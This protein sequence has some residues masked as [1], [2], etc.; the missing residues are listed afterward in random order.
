MTNPIVPSLFGIEKFDEK[1]NFTLWQGLVRDAL[2]LQ[3]LNDALSSTKPIK[4][5]DDK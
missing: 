2:V 3:G 5:K 4:M 1:Q